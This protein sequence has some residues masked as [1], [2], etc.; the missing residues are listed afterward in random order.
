MAAKTKLTDEEKYYRKLAS[1]CKTEWSYKSPIRKEVFKEARAP[2]WSFKM[3]KFICKECRQV[4]AKSE[5]ECDHVTAICTVVD[6]K[7]LQG[8]LAHLRATNVTKYGLQIL[9][10]PCHQKK[11]KKDIKKK[12]SKK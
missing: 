6:V 5:V 12:V 10:K 7:T 2:S 3:Q 9:C 8:L 11:T 1:T 4:F